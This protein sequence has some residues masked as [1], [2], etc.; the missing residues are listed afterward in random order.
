M[1]C[2]VNRAR[3]NSKR[4]LKKIQEN[5]FFVV[6]QSNQEGRT[7][8]RIGGIN[9][10]TRLYNQREFVTQFGH[11]RLIS[12]SSKSA[13]QHIISLSA[14]QKNNKHMHTDPHVAPIK[15]HLTLQE[16]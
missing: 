10:C 9:G 8:F 4:K 12:L 1:Q 6:L 11:S 14:L 15:Q 16:I 2:E 5:A 3:L 13:A 7:V